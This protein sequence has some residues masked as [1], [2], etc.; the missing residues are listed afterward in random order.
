MY[1]SVSW[2]FQCYKSTWWFLFGIWN[3]CVYIYIYI[4][5]ILYIIYYIYI[6]YISKHRQNALLETLLI[7]IKMCAGFTTHVIWLDTKVC[8]V[9]GKPTQSSSRR[10]SSFND[11]SVLLNNCVVSFTK[12]KSFYSLAHRLWWKP[13]AYMGTQAK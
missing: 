4:L 10:V 12:V 3:V 1:F 5:Y 11:S 7:A 9:T 8:S 6:I 13:K 2:Y